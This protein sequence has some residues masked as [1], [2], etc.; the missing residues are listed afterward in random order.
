MH[1]DF[2]MNNPARR[3]PPTSK[4]KLA[5]FATFGSGD[6]NIWGQSRRGYGWIGGNYT[7]DGRPVGLCNSQSGRH[8]RQ[9]NGRDRVIARDDRYDAGLPSV[10]QQFRLLAGDQHH[11]LRILQRLGESR[12]REFVQDEDAS[13]IRAW[14]IQTLHAPRPTPGQCVPQ[15][16]GENGISDRKPN[17]SHHW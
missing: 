14:T 3:S 5:C 7:R 8:N 15:A 17:R 2:E 13:L 10:G 1:L 6:L 4:R 9:Q 11:S 12:E 16:P